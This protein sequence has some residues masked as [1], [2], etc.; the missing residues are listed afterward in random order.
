MSPLCGFE[1]HEDWSFGM[2]A[3]QINQFSDTRLNPWLCNSD[4]VTGTMKRSLVVQII[5]SDHSSVVTRY[6]LRLEIAQVC[7]I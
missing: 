1:L 5:S 7:S 3:I 6:I 4:H 2:L